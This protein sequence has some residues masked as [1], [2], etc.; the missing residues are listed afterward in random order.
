LTFGVSDGAAL[1]SGLLPITA[2]PEALSIG[3]TDAP[4][5]A[6]MTPAAHCELMFHE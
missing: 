2:A 5:H 4:R 6:P 1:E 3:E